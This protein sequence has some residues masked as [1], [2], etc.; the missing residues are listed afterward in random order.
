MK[1]TAFRIQECFGFRDSDW[2]DLE[3][4]TNLIYVLG[5]NS[6]GKTSFLT[7]LAHFAPRLKPSSYPNFANFDPSST[8]PLLLAAYSIQPREFTLEAF[9]NAF[10]REMDKV[11]QGFPALLA[12][13]E[14][15]LYKDM[16]E[17][18]LYAVYEHILAGINIVGR[19]FVQR[20]AGGDYS[21]SA[22]EDHEVYEGRNNH[23]TDL[24]RHFPKQLGLQINA[25]G[26]LNV[27]GN[28]YP[29]TQLSAA[30]IENLLVKQLPVITFLKKPILFLMCYPM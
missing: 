7:A 26:Q 12:S 10:R 25:N 9:I 11:N 14:Y 3:D 13:K 27:N 17:P 20:D 2:I 28:W 5:R 23:F 22:T 4:P 30:Q 21:F 6:S 8:K 1:L 15:Q 24:F 18:K 29:F 19:C 16:L